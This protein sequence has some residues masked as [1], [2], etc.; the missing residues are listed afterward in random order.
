MEHPFRTHLYTV[1]TLLLEIWIALAIVYNSTRA[2]AEPLSAFQD[3][4]QA[5]SFPSFPLANDKDFQQATELIYKKQYA[6][7]HKAFLKLNTIHPNNIPV[8]NNLAITHLMLERPSLALETMRQL[9]LDSDAILAVSYQNFLKLNA[10]QTSL[11][12]KKALGL[13]LFDIQKPHLTLIAK[14]TTRHLVE[15]TEPT[16]NADGGKSVLER[17]AAVEANMRPLIE[18]PR[19]I[20]KTEKK[21]LTIFVRAWKKA[22]EEQNLD[23]YFAKYMD[24]YRPSHLIS[25]E[26]WTEKREQRILLPT[27]VKVKITGIVITKIGT[28]K[29]SMVFRQEYESNIYRGATK[30]EL[31]VELRDG[32]H[33]IIT[34]RVLQQIR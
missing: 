28:L 18:D 30:K 3:S 17:I 7:A 2:Y 26:A 14:D 29:Y 25:H 22:W 24:N 33:R 19:S 13:A 10:F 23:A 20:S 32:S 5:T 27:N 16:K 31:L 11:D 21:Q 1:L 8:M 6:K 9:F 34:E 15:Q 4:D 12:F